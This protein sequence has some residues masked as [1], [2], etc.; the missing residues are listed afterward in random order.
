MS[1]SPWQ[2]IFQH[3][4]EFH[5]AGSLEEAGALFEAILEHNPAHFPTLHR[6]AAIRRQQGRLEE[7]LALLTRAIQANPASADL[8]NG[9][10]NTLH[11]LGRD[12]EAVH[13]CRRAICLRANFPQAQFNLGACLRSLGR[14]EEAAAAY[15]EAIEIQPQ[16]AEAHSNL[17]TVLARLNR[18]AE[19]I[20]SFSAALA[21]DPHARL[22]YSNIGLAL[23][24]MNRQEEAIPFFERAREADPQAIQP[25]FNQSLA[26]LEIGDFRRGLPGYETRW[27][28]AEIHMQLPEYSQPRWRGEELAGKTILLQAEQGLG[29][30][31]LFARYAPA[32]AARGATVL[33]IAPRSL[34]PLLRAIPGVSQVL[35]SGDALPHFDCWS[36]LGSLP[37]AFHTTVETIPAPVFYLPAPHESPTVSAFERTRDT[38]PAVGICWAGSAEY[39]DDHNRSLPLDIF[40]RLFQIAGVRFVSLQQ[41]LRPGDAQILAR[42]PDIDLTSDAQGAGLADTAALIG[43][44][45]LVITVDT[46]I[47]HL[48]GALGRPVWVLL[49]FHAYWVWLRGRPDTPWYP[50][51]RLLRQTE[52]GDW[53]PTVQ[54]AAV[55]LDAAAPARAF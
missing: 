4:V 6:L 12:A 19:A 36:P 25:V 32:L 1:E 55:A 49:P 9:I 2:P 43:R 8:E 44:L 40:Q 7:S 18:P 53:R 39:P 35:S 41:K 46:A 13:H 37:L 45:D 26:L 10:A 54:R 38:R 15:R 17:G 11:S 27:Q 42:Y 31:I 24:S 3:A 14:F 29:D 33:F 48:A 16:Y 47:A 22:A 5:T 20:A 34:A 50:T 51:A 28:V 52:I 23:T 30:T 21:A